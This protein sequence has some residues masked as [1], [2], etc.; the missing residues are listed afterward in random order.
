MLLVGVIA[1]APADDRPCAGRCGT[2]TQCVADLC[3]VAAVEAEPEAEL[4][5]EP[6]ARKKRRRGA[7][8]DALSAD[9]LRSDGAPPIVDD[10]SVPRFRGDADQTIDLDSGSERLSDTAIDRE[11]SALDGAFQEC[12]RDGVARVGELGSGRVSYEF[13]IGSDGRVTG[14][15]ATAPAH[16]VDA[17]IVPCVRRA[18]FRHRFPRFDGPT[19]SASSSFSI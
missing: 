19:M 3:V 13:G 15:N 11:L 4:E 8:D 5:S 16:L 14:V 2:G 12:I 17:G 18:V 6:R 1:C 9:D 7:S 10:S